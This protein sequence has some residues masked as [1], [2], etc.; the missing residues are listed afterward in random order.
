[1]DQKT[2]KDILRCHEVPMNYTK[3][4]YLWI[5][6]MEAFKNDPSFTVV[7]REL[8]RDF[9]KYSRPAFMYIGAFFEKNKIHEK[10]DGYSTVIARN[11]G[12]EL[13]CIKDK[14]GAGFLYS[15]DDPKLYIEFGS[16]PVLNDF[17]HRFYKTCGVKVIFHYSENENGN[18][19]AV[20]TL[21]GTKYYDERGNC[22][23]GTQIWGMLDDLMN[24]LA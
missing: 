4:R 7:N 21:N 10:K 1:M 20:S 18:A 2:V 12:G 22:G 14:N 13:K 19:Q 23:I 5:K 8:Y 9:E 11:A 17:R 16:T 3:C 24:N 15:T 6:V